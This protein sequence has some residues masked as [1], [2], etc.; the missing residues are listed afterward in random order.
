MEDRCLI[1]NYDYK[2]SS[3]KGRMV[4]ILCLMV[5]IVLLIFIVLKKRSYWWVILYIVVSFYVIELIVYISTN[6]SYYDMTHKNLIYGTVM[7]SNE[8][9]KYMD[10]PKSKEYIEKVNMGYEVAGNSRILILCLARDVE[11]NVLLSRNKLESIGKDFLEYKIVIFE[12]DSDDESRKL[13]KGWMNENDNVELMDCCDMGSCDCLLKNAKGY[14]MG[15]YSYNKSRIDKMRFY[16]ETLLRYATGKYY[17]Y[18]YVMVYDF[19]ISGIVYKDGLMTSFSSNKDWDMVFANGLQSLPKVISSK[20]VIYDSLPYLSDTM[21]YEHK[22]SLSQLDKEHSKLMKYKIGDDLV[23]CKSGFNGIAI[24]RMEGLLNSTYMNTKRYCEH[25][26]L[27]QDM[28][29]K[30]YDKVYFNPNMVLFVGQNGPDRTQVFKEF[31]N[32]FKKLDK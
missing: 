15:S 23:K 26:D 5:F 32:F 25:V 8:L 13:L 7:D 12:N 29:N 27:H 22:N 14:E 9:S 3:S 21:D 16:R 10:V 6:L 1:E 2:Q 19:D 31:G 18:D 28:Y 20:L 24:Y 11:H 4:F 30:G 17:Y